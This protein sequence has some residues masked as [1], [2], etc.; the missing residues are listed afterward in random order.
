MA[1]YQAPEDRVRRQRYQAGHP[2]VRISS[3]G[4]GRWWQAVIPQVSGETVV[5][6]FGLAELLDDLEAQGRRAWGAGPVS[7]QPAR[8]RARLP[9]PRPAG[10]AKPLYRYP[11]RPGRNFSPLCGRA[12]PLNS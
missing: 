2:D 11:P 4:V 9:A 12:G 5:I 1:R 10:G 8:E 6:R 7:L 3:G